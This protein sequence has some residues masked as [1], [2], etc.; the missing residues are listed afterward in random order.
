[1]EQIIRS[2]ST[3]RSPRYAARRGERCCMPPVIA[4]AST[5]VSSARTLA[6]LVPLLDS[7]IVQNYFSLKAFAYCCIRSLANRLLRLRMQQRRAGSGLD[8]GQFFIVQVRKAA[9]RVA[10]RQ[11]FLQVQPL[12]NAFCCIV[13]IRPEARRRGYN[14][15]PRSNPYSSA[16]GAGGR[17]PAGCTHGNNPNDQS[18][19]D[20]RSSRRSLR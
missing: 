6:C 3:L 2:H 12:S 5:V 11:P 18:N 19:F 7:E 16:P 8:L 17:A 15:A 13:R 10:P 4:F 20:V 1:M 9:L 14:L